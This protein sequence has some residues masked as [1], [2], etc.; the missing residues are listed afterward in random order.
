MILFTPEE[1]MKDFNDDLIAL[2]PVKGYDPP[3]LPT[4]QE[5]RK[6]PYLLKS[7][8]SRW[9][10]NVKVIACIGILG[11]SMITLAGCAGDGISSGGV[12]GGN[13]DP[14]PDLRPVEMHHG[15]AASAPIYVTCPTE[16][17]TIDG[18]YPPDIEFDDPDD[19]DFI[20]VSVLL[21]DLELRAHFGGS[22]G[23]PFY[24]VYMT[25]HEAM[26]IIRSQLEL[27]G[28]RFDAAPPANAVE[29]QVDDFTLQVDRF[30]FDLFDETKNVAVTNVGS[31][32]GNWLAERVAEEFKKQER[33]ISVG[34]F[35]TPGLN[36]DSEFDFEWD[37]NWNDNGSPLE[38]SDEEVAEAKERARPILEERLNVYIQEFIDFLHAEGIL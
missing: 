2:T 25:E 10:H 28:L 5:A 36:P 17:E 37:W 34:V 35:Y 8:P 20:P 32:W 19:F 4:L 38:P 26:S 29:L 30:G 18:Q 23:G 24:V 15:G 7:L 16:Q 11:A 13:P 1:I 3:K 31:G 21:E 14:T 33:D 22:G 6:D 9:Q 12:A 27:A